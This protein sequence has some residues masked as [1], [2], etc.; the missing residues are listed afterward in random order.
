MAQSLKLNGEI[1]QYRNKITIQE[2]RDSN[3]LSVIDT[4]G[5]NDKRQTR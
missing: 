4:V 1:P 2:I 3:L 5:E